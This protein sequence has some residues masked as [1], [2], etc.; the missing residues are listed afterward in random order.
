MCSGSKDTD[1]IVWDVIAQRGLFRLKGHKDE[2]TALQF[3][4]TSASTLILSSSKDSLLKVWDTETQSCTHTLVG[5]RT[6][7]WSFAVRS[8][9]GKSLFLSFVA[10]INR[11][12]LN[13]CCCSRH[14]VHRPHVARH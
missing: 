4:E 10:T 14:R 11:R 2:V 9:R 13:E 5:H 12:R 1:I 6:S 3:L 8:K 7:V